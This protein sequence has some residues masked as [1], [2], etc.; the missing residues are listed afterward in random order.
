MISRKIVW[1]DSKINLFN[2][3]LVNN[4]ESMQ[5]LIRDVNTESIDHVTQDFTRYL[6][7]NAF[8]VF[9]QTTHS[10]SRSA[11]GKKVNN[12]WFDKNCRNSKNE[13]KIARNT[14]NRTKTV[15]SRVNFTRA[16]TRYNRIKKSKVQIQM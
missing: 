4:N 15:E 12:K 14:F 10:K 13:F 8:E 3:Q 7:D 2:S 1:D 11:P 6:H 5:R 16:R 9:G